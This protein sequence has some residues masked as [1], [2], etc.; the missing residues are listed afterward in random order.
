MN[1]QDG[2]LVQIHYEP[3]SFT[4]SQQALGRSHRVGQEEE[5]LLHRLRD[6]GGLDAYQSAGYHAANRRQLEST[7]R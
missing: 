4:Q 1:L 5:V 3:T 7:S 6:D 2:G